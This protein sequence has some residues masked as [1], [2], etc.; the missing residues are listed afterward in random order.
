MCPSRESYENSLEVMI[1]E[2]LSGLVHRTPKETASS[3]NG[4]MNRRMNIEVTF[5]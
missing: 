3:Q 4:R 2:T 1:G 5:H